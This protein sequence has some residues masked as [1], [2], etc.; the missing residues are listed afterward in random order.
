LSYAILLENINPD[1]YAAKIDTEFN[2]IRTAANTL[3]FEVCL[4]SRENISITPEQPDEEEGGRYVVLSDNSDGYD[5]FTQIFDH[6]NAIDPIFVIDNGD[7]VFNGTPNQYRLFDMSVN[8]IS[9]TVCTT[10]GNHDIYNNGRDIYTKLY[11]PDTARLISGTAFFKRVTVYK[12]LFQRESILYMFVFFCR[13][14][15]YKE[16]NCGRKEN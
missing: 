8:Q 9:S 3:R 11:G 12:R 6:I 5:I 14:N 10:L 7:L 13:T 1:F 4:D 15:T 16:L 2:P